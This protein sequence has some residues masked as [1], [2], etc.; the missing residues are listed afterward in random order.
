MD[1]VEEGRRGEEG[2]VCTKADVTRLI[3]DGP[4][5][6]QYE[7]EKKRLSRD[8]PADDSYQGCNPAQR[9]LIL[10]A[11]LHRQLFTTAQ[12]GHRDIL[13]SCVKRAVRH[14]HPDSEEGKSRGVK[15]IKKEISGESS[16]AA[17]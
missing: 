10:Y 15:R 9:R 8:R 13:P 5:A 1:V 16:T 11:L 4:T 12:R 7:S 6:W 17:K 14:A 3:A 2:E